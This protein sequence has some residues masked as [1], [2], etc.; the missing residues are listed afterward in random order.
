[1]TVIDALDEG[2]RLRVFVDVNPIIG[3]VVLLKEPP[4]PLCVG[5][6]LGPVNFSPNPPMDG[7]RKA[8][9]G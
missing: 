4:S 7:V 6:R 5:A 9:G 2:E 8:E 1:M 3:N